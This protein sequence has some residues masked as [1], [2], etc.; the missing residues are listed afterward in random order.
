M[1]KDL[2]NFIFIPAIYSA[3]IT[4][5]IYAAIQEL[6]KFN[7]SSQFFVFS[8]AII[9]IIISE[10][11][12]NYIARSKTVVLNMDFSDDINELSHLFNKIILPLGLYISIIG[13]G[14][15]NLS[16]NILTIILI[17]TFV[18]FFVL[19]VNIRSFFKNSLDLESKT[20]FVYDFFKF[21][22]FFLGG[23]VIVNYSQGNVQQVFGGVLALS[24]I[25]HLLLLIR[26]KFA[27]NRHYILAIIG[28]IIIAESAS[29]LVA[30]NKYNQLQI[31][32]CII[33]IFYLSLAII[34]HAINRTLTRSVL[35]E[36]LLVL[37]IA[38]SILLG[39]S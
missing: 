12:I 15:Y 8:A 26:Q 13:F 31:S 2:G 1:R 10:I 29:L 36:Y 3:G 22:I 35:F 25:L 16:S 21:I 4:L 30:A 14:Y 6:H 32:L 19:F 27:F 7:N 39:V 23:D 9:T 18:L 20:H 33:F 17:L 28:S 24:A 5:A 38:L 34:Q 37:L 11:I